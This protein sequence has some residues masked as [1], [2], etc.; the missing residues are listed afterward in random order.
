MRGISAA[1]LLALAGAFFLGISLPGALGANVPAPV[2]AG[3]AI[4][5][6]AGMAGCARRGRLV[7]ATAL[8]AVAALAAGVANRPTPSE[9]GPLAAAIGA[10]GDERLDRPIRLAGT[11]TRSPEEFSDRTELRLRVKEVFAN[12]R[13]TR[14]P[15]LARI[16]V[17]GEHRHRL[18]GLARGA[19]VEVW[20][21]VARRRPPG[22]PG[23]RSVTGPVGLFGRTKSALLVTGERPAAAFSRLIRRL[24]LGIR[25]RFTGSGLSPE[26]AA[27]I[28]AILTGDRT[29]TA[30]GVVRSFRDAGTL[31]V[32]AVSGLHVGLVS[33][34]LYG[35]F[36]LFGTGR[37]TALTLLLILL[38]FH[39]ALSG[40]SP[41]V[42]RAALMAAVVILGIRHG[43][44]GSALNGIGLAAI[45]LLAWDPWNASDVGFQLSFA[46]T[47]AIVGVLGRRDPASGTWDPPGRLQRLGRW[48]RGALAVTLAAQLGAFPVIAWHFH[49]VVLAAIPVSVPATLLA[50]PILG[51]GFGWLLLGDVPILG[52]LLLVGAGKS[53]EALLAIS[54]WGAALPFAT[55]GIAAPG[56]PFLAAWFA[57]ALVVLA[58]RSRLVRAPA[59]LALVGLAAFL[60]PRGTAGDGSLRVTALDVGMGDALVLGL[61]AGGT[62]VVDAGAAYRDYSAGERVVAPFL[63]ETGGLPVRAAVATHGDLDHIGGFASLFR[64]VAA[65][66][67][68]RGAGLAADERPAVRF[69]RRDISR[70]EIPARLLRTGEE[71]AFGGAWFR[72]L[73]ADVPVAP[74]TNE[75]SLVLMVEYAGARVLLTGDAGEPTERIL[76][77]QYGEGLAADVLKVGHHGSR[78]STTPEFLDAVRPGIAIVSAREDRRR[79]LPDPAVLERLAD[80]GARVFRT[81]RDG[82][83]T[84]RIGPDGAL[85]VRAYRSPPP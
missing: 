10:L 67:F 72:V 7:I 49:R 28:V 69:L 18:R 20:T 39:A 59:A 51:C 35:L 17:E 16:R 57:L 78:Y 79:R 84:V 53:A 77:E 1:P 38:P 81:D 31:H 12:R 58:V 52:S 23:G 4:L 74:G 43:I 29:L 5:L 15:G 19:D 63:L 85:S 34:L 30:G 76:V 2:S 21:R 71:F 64:E 65:D 9:Q 46:A 73:F 83:V 37:R 61:P 50:G 25:D 6:L 56:W 13:T 11:L 8:L 82:A 3:V 62:V 40:G 14:A 27:V 48:S 36:V 26:A 32:M 60:L 70:R 68:W 54:A 42:L 24:R 75:G 47:L 80:R 33:L 22:N 41:S 45:L 55:S 66:S 44:A